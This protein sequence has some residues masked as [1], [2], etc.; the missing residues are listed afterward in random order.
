MSRGVRVRPSPPSRRANDY[1]PPRLSRP[2]SHGLKIQTVDKGSHF[3]HAA[4]RKQFAIVASVDPVSQ[5]GRVAGDPRWASHFPRIGARISSEEIRA[6][7]K[8]KPTH[9]PRPKPSHQDN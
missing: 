5:I 9:K 2:R 3:L 6:M 1:W 7:P 8:S 4:A